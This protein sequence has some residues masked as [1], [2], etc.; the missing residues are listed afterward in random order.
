MITFICIF[1]YIFSVFFMSGYIVEGDEE[2]P[3]IIVGGIV[4]GL[5]FAPF[6]LPF[7]LGIYIHKNS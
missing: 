7:N 2:N 4:L 6:L 5:I 1:Y 3:W